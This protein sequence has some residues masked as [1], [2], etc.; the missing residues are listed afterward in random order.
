MNFFKSKQSEPSLPQPKPPHLLIQQALTD[1]QNHFSTFLHHHHHHHHTHHVLF[2]PN[3]SCIKTHLD[4]TFSNLFN[5]AKQTIEAGFSSFRF[6]PSS[7]S[8]AIKNPAWA[9]IAE[10]ISESGLAM[11]TEAIEERLA[12]VPVYALSNASQEFVLISGEN[13]EKSLGLFCFKEEDAKTLLEQMT[14]MDPGMRQGSEVVAVALNKVFQLKLDGVA[15]R[16]I[17]E[18]SQIKNALRVR[19]KAGVSDESF[20]GVPVFQINNIINRSTS[21]IN[22]EMGKASEFGREG[23]GRRRDVL[24]QGD[25]RR[26]QVEI[27]SLRYP[28]GLARYA[29][30]MGSM[31]VSSVY[32][33]AMSPM[34]QVSRSLILRSQDK[35][36][37]PVFFRK[38]D[39]E[40][41]L[42]RASRQQKQLNPAFREGDIQVAVLEEIIQGMKDSKMTMWDDVVFIPPGF[43][44]STN[45]FQK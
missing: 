34:W 19:E 10:K 6:G 31:H 24:E 43:D 17:P 16:L 18:S 23:K 11:S 42:L 30:L 7:G 44:V 35:R 14:S 28:L 25:W 36:Y 13:T 40:N 32:I 27:P 4:S 22:R 33:A 37:R 21:Y 45:P 39:L 26:P 38:E 12:G 29:C 8:P 5:N 41:S 2:N 3:P 9:R 1:L 15:F 20:S